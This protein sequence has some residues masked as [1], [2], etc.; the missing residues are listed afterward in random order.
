MTLRDPGA[1]TVLLDELRTAFDAPWQAGP[2]G[3]SGL[4]TPRAAS[5][6]GPLPRAGETY[7][8]VELGG[9]P[10]L[11]IDLYLQIYARRLEI[12]GATS[13]STIGLA[14]TTLV[15]GGPDDEMGNRPRE[16]A[17][18]RLAAADLQWFQA[19]DD[20]WRA[21]ARQLAAEEEAFWA[22][23]TTGTA[24]DTALRSLLQAKVE[25]NALGV[26][27][28]LPPPSAVAE[29]V[30]R[31]LPPAAAAEVTE[32]SYLPTSGAVAYDVLER[33]SW[34]VALALR[35]RP[36]LPAPARARFVQEALFFTFESLDTDH[37]SY[38]LEQYPREVARRYGRRAGRDADIV[39]RIQE[40]SDRS[41]RRR[42]HRQW[43]RRAL[44]ENTGD[45]GAR[46]RLLLL[47]DF[48]GSAREFDEEK[49]RR[50]MSLWRSLFALADA[51]GMS[52]STSG[53][54]VEGMC[55]AVHR[56]S[57]SV[58]I[59]PVFVATLPSADEG[60]TGCGA[61]AHHLGP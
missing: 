28:L 14:G 8:V 41:W 36:D 23:L 6:T 30:A 56:R 46:R 42:L 34:V 20:R 53:A 4:S 18:R 38:W 60:V 2:A 61:E 44:R 39:A 49:R 3:G 7:Y 27:S 57:G 16:V 22:D 50:N 24:S 5:V 40:A 47:H 11:Y 48:L 29:R 33:E 17:A 37:R 58:A 43:A 59:D 51:L 45:P 1:T 15:F 54:T 32:A 31:H 26:D 19:L 21:A 9:M 52:L 55:A 35:G 12:W 10:V 13:R 25:L